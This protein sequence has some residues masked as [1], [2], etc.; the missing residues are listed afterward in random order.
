MYRLFY[1]YHTIGDILMI[2]FNN[3][4]QVTRV[5]K[6]VNSVAL[7]CHD[8]LIGIN[9]FN[10]SNTVRLKAKGMI[11]NPAPAFIEVINHILINDGLEA[12]PLEQESNFIVGQ[13]LE[14]IKS[15][16]EF[17]IAKVDI[18]SRVI[19]ALASNDSIIVNRLVVIALP[20]TILGNGKTAILQQI[21]NIYCE[22]HLCLKSELNIPLIEGKDEVYLLD[23]FA[24]I[25]Q[26]F[27]AKE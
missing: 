3:Q 11:I 27:F 2:V 14:L 21:D 1:D 4:K 7:F 26:D 16:N 24:E 8:E 13:V 19:Y 25:G 17:F 15:E 5:D 12:L 23:E 6:R 18:S 22:G 9:I 20:G 10:I